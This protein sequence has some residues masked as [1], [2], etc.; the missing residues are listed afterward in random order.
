MRKISVL[1]FCCVLG[2]GYVYAQ[3]NTFPS[4]GAAGIGTT[5][6]NASSLLEIKSTTKGI[7][8]PRMSKIKRDSIASPATG[9]L[10]FQTNS[11]PGFYYYNGTAWTAVSSNGTNKSLSNLSAPTA[12]N[13]DLLP[14]SNN[15]IDL[16][17]AGLNWRDVYVA[18]SYYIGSTKVLT[19]PGTNNTFIGATGNT[20]NTGTNNT[21]LGNQALRFNTSGGYN[22]ATGTFAMFSNTTANNNTASGYGSLY[23]N[24]SGS[25]NTATGAFSLA[26]NSS[27][28]GNTAIG[29][30][31]LNANT[32][33]TSNTASGNNAL[34]NNTEGFNNTADGA[35]ALSGNT[36]GYLNTATGTTA[37]NANTT[38]FYNTANGGN[39]LKSNVGGVGNTATGAFTLYANTS[40]A[41]NSAH[42]SS[43]LA[44]NTTGI[45]NTADGVNALATN[46]TGNYNTAIGYGALQT[47]S[48]SNHNVGVGYYADVSVDGLTNATAIGDGASVN[49]S[50]KIRLGNG[51]VSVIEGN[52]VYTVSDGRFKENI[53]DDVKGLAFINELRP[54]VYNFEARKFDEFVHKN[55]AATFEKIS[56]H[57]DYSEA[58]HSRKSGFIAQEVEKAAKK[59]GYD[60]D[61]VHIPQNDGDNYS[62]A[63][64]EFVVP[65]VKAVQELSAKNDQL[66]LKVQQFEN[67]KTENDQLKARLD[68]IEQKLGL[69]SGTGNSTGVTLD[70][71]T[72]E[73]NVPNPF[74]HPTT[75]G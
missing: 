11:T 21:A 47:N 5:T 39:A 65:L 66:N 31:A 64:A 15:S 67:L 20:A 74:N 71:A 68:L 54:V 62:L 40:G 2:S 41:Y 6:P 4:T 12:V 26:Y 27:G 73:Q 24:T 23:T 55:N 3:T 59:T 61:G 69:T 60:F 42:G 75:I 25:N 38:G 19:L 52:A 70:K 44:N 28:S 8:I 57:L 43:A 1:M 36:T 22:T 37:L 32:I 29:F 9:L 53:T 50:N 16:G 49:A 18:G 63:Y 34:H 48:T 10:I 13:V 56:P 17:S 72:L 35:D 46:T 14:G 33:G 7:L 51:A 30:S 45:D 58:E